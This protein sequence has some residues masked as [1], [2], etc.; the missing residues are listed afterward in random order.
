MKD[1]VHREKVT[2]GFTLVSISTFD[3]AKLVY[4]HC[5]DLPKKSEVLLILLTGGVHPGDC[6]TGD[7]VSL[8][9]LGR[10]NAL[11]Q[12]LGTHFKDIA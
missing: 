10:A 11:P 9:T 4:T 2:N 8:E 6:E 3:F 7:R 12:D 1:R 5:L